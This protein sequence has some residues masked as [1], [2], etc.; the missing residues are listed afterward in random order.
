[1]RRGIV[2]AVP[3]GQQVAQ[4]LLSG[5][6]LLLVAVGV[7]VVLVLVGG[8]PVPHGL[9]HAVRVDM[10]LHQLFDKPIADT[11][12]VHAAFSLAWIAWL[13]LS[14]CVVVEMVSW[15][16]G[17]AP[18]RVPGSRPMQAV[19]AFLVGTT[20]AFM[21]ADHL[22]GPGVHGTPRAAM[23]A[24]ASM[25]LPKASSRL[26]R[27]ALATV[28]PPAGAGVVDPGAPLT[29]AYR[30][31]TT[32][33]GRT[34]S[35]ADSRTGAPLRGSAL[36]DGR[37][38]GLRN[39][40]AV[41]MVEGSSAWPVPATTGES[42]E[43]SDVVETVS[44]PPLR[45][46]V[47]QPHDTLWSIA[48]SQ[49]GSPLLWPEIAQANY[50]RPQPDGGA[51]TD[52][53]WIDPGWVLVL[54]T[55]GSVADAVS[56][57]TSASAAPAGPV[58]ASGPSVSPPPPTAPP[59]TTP[60][61]PTST[62][63]PS[64]TS[65]SPASVPPATE[66]MPPSDVAPRVGLDHTIRTQADPVGAARSVHRTDGTPEGHPE[67]GH[68]GFPV[69]PIGAGLL[70]AGLVGIID[71]MRRAQQRHRRVGEHIRLPQPAL[72]SLE[73]RLRISDDPLAPYAIDA[74]LR[75]LASGV[76]STG[77]PVVAGVQVHPDDI[78]LI[79][80][81]DRWTGTVTDPFEDRLGSSSWFVSRRL[82]SGA[83]PYDAEGIRDG[84]AP[85]PALV[86]VGRSDAGPC[87]V[88]LEAMGSLA[89]VGEPAACDGLLRALALELATSFWADQF[90]L[91]L[92]GF[93]QEL[94]RFERVR[95]MP[96]AV[97]LVR[98]LEHRGR[99]GR[100]LL[101][102]AGYGSFSEARLVAGSDTWD[103]LVVLCGPSVGPS[104]ARD[105]VDQAG[106]AE[107]GLAVVVCGD[108]GGSRHTLRLDGLGTSSPLDLLGTVVWPQRVESS[109]LEGLGG[110]LT[111]AAD[112]SSVPASVDPYRSIR[113][114]LPL[115]R[116][117]RTEGFSPSGDEDDRKQTAPRTG[118][119]SEYSG[120][121]SP[122]HSRLAP[123]DLAG[124]DEVGGT[125]ETD[126]PPG[127]NPEDHAED[128]PEVEV[129]VLGTVEV[130][131]NARQFTRAWAKELVVYLAM[132][133]EGVSNDTWAT[134]L[135]PDRLMAASSLH[136]TASVAR[137]SLG[138]ARD[139]GDHLP[140][141]HGRLV[142]ADTVGTDWGR[143][144]RLADSEHPGHWRA[145]MELV[146]GRPFDG[147]RAS[148]WPILE[149][150][151][152]AI[153]A[154]VV[155][156]ATRL[157]SRCLAAR[158][159]ASAEWAA[160]RGLLV[161]PYDERLYRILLRSADLAGNPAG[162]EAVMSELL[163]L[164]ADGVEPF[165]SIHPETTDLYRALTRRRSFAPSSR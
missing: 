71:R 5:S 29:D 15:V 24:S 54:P 55:D 155:D 127:G 58:P 95:V 31:T 111:T 21:S 74:A 2:P 38:T 32:K 85:C 97:P 36:S 128:L 157:A 101:H 68:G 80:R 81:D 61:P 125:N 4:G 147:L 122:G 143:F 51:L 75:T 91:V 84:E 92:V 46:Y 22:P 64:T 77:G 132:H 156:V 154:S 12:I 112:L 129:L 17:R 109:E 43:L 18:V 89:V 1:M 73:R 49:L 162:V 10:S 45:T 153:E 90:D 59:T 44:A 62:P 117:N 106:D 78:E 76:S 104:E 79:P 148:D 53:H 124:R 9:I 42:A 60:P 110:L 23:A 139:G 19:A 57:S 88:N 123:S 56:P 107:T 140:K 69:T 130:Q 103:A 16:S 93:G 8:S 3:R 87:L 145:A 114:P 98:E 72:S 83:E 14:V 121:D 70:G 134:A 138:Q 20:L 28:K 52:A 115:V 160:R 100:S 102:T 150:L 33:T 142:L 159:P 152:A 6:T 119:A 30:R 13:W 105:L 161:S 118:G 135:W 99:D 25:T 126:P 11:W 141:G 41:G 50:G 120:M 96:D 66:S 67:G 146:R 144:V 149:G 27:L 48:G 65:L 63:A 131:G 94:S 165:D 35:R 164:V 82:L 163:H 39:K 40:Q 34:L 137:R 7:P 108:T 151:S 37:T 86:T 116:P 133:P 47:V 136:S 26:P 158:D 113:A